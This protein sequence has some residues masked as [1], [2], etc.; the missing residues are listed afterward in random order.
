M[1]VFR[2]SSVSEISFLPKYSAVL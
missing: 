2:T 1:F